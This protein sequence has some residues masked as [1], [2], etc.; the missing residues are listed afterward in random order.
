VPHP[1]EEK[2]SLQGARLYPAPLLCSKLKPPKISKHFAL[3]GIRAAVKKQAIRDACGCVICAGAGNIL[4]HFNLAPPQLLPV[5]LK[6][7][8]VLAEE[9]V[10]VNAHLPS[11]STP[12][13]SVHLVKKQK[14]DLF[15]LIR[16]SDSRAYLLT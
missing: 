13:L 2:G 9:V 11:R 3:V 15:E 14:L 5:E 7:F 4:S 8:H 16:E 6:H 1:P 10:A 12:T